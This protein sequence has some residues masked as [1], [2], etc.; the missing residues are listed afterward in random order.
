MW[1]KNGRPVHFADLLA[2]S[3]SLYQ[4]MLVDVL[5][6]PAYDKLTGHWAENW[7]EREKAD[8]DLKVANYDEEW[9]TVVGWRVSFLNFYVDVWT[10]VPQNITVFEGKVFQDVV[11]LNW[12]P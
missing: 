3:S 4:E 9:R 8:L 7:L 10:L 6:S 2:V 5:S 1:Q 11:K 12:G